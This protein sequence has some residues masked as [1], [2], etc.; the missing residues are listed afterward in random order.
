MSSRQSWVVNIITSNSNSSSRSSVK[1]DMAN[2]EFSI[3]LL[4]SLYNLVLCNTRGLSAE[5]QFCLLLLLLAYTTLWGRVTG[6]VR[7]EEDGDG[8]GV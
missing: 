2:D 7:W 3:P 6:Y 5:L 1:G 8:D 4:W